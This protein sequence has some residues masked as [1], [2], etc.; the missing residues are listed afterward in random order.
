MIEGMENFKRL[1]EA[2]NRYEKAFSEGVP[3]LDGR[4]FSVDEIEHA[5]LTG[6]KLN[7]ED[8]SAYDDEDDDGAK[9]I[10]ER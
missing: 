7:P 9:T 1:I 5:I 4:S 6:V 8:G 10:L 2:R 3:K